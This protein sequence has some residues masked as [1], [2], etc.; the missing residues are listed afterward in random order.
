MASRSRT[1]DAALVL[2]F[3]LA[4]PAVAQDRQPVVSLTGGLGNTLGGLGAGAEYY[5]AGGRLSL[6][7]GLGYWPEE[8]NCEHGSLAGAGA[9]RGFAGSRRHRAFLEASYSLLEISCGTGDAI[10][11][12]YGPGLLLGYRYTGSDGFTFSAG[13]GLG[14]PGPGDSRELMVLLGL[15]Y[16]WL[17]PSAEHEDSHRRLPTPP[18]PTA[19]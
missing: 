5:F 12:R 6:A 13:A 18:W 10:D 8:I 2:L 14:K 7:G 16:T 1:A 17:A 3:L 4:A 15:G 9:V 19:P 11:R